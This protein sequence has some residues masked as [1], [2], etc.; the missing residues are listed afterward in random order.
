MT[1]EVKKSKSFVRVVFMIDGILTIR[2][3]VKRRLT[4][5]AV[6]PV[7]AALHLPFDFATDI[8]I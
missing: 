7:E 6:S 3:D 8:P 4:A 1:N 5:T 2:L